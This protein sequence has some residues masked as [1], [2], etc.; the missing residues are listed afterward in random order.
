MCDRDKRSLTCPLSTTP[1]PLLRPGAECGCEGRSTLLFV[2]MSGVAVLFLLLLL[3]AAVHVSRAYL[4]GEG[5]TGAP[6]TT[7]THTVVDTSGSCASRACHPLPLKLTAK[8][9]ESLLS[10]VFSTIRIRVRGKMQPMAFCFKVSLFSSYATNVFL[11]F[12]SNTAT[13]RWKNSVWPSKSCD[14]LLR[15]KPKRL[16]TV[17]KTQ[18][19]ESD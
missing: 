3:L 5:R 6:T 11:F 14:V 13:S 2:L 17:L 12:S 4:S 1:P 8:P 18:E 15:K 19:T 10:V 7:T 9:H 16:P